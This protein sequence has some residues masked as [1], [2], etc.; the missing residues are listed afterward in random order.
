V[1]TETHVLKQLA[2][3]VSFLKERVVEIQIDISEIN[4]DLHEVR[5]EYVKKIKR[6][7]KKGKF[8]S[9]SGIKELKK[10]IENS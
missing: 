1:A 8:K 7:D 6:I 3:D 2:E 10:D 4:A 9:F 5:P